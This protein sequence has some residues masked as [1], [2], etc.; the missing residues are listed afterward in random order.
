MIFTQLPLTLCYSV[1][2][3]S[4]DNV[5]IE[6]STD[7][8]NEPCFGFRGQTSPP[9]GNKVETKV[10]IPCL[11]EIAKKLFSGLVFCIA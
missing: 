11:S 8:L 7:G 10:L 5:L 9:S 6:H 1:Y 3:L 2:R 4:Y